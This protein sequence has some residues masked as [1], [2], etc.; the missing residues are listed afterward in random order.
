MKTKSYPLTVL[1]TEEDEDIVFIEYR[2]HL[3]VNLS[4][5]KEIVDNRLDFTE[6]KKHYLV[7]DVTNVKNVT[8][9]AKAYLLNPEAGI[10]NILGAAF[11]A[12]NPV[13][14]MLA[15]IFIKQ[16]KNF[17]SK[18]FARKSDAIRWIKELKYI[19]F[20]LSNK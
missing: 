2:K 12:G 16:P 18:F 3:E 8:Q 11:I 13:A 7:I 9:D 20:N 4:F 6:G 5:A 10:K 15:N 19:N 14:A 17:Q 1:H